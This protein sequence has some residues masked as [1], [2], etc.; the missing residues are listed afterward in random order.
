MSRYVREQEDP[1]AQRAM[2][3]ILFGII[4]VHYFQQCLLLM[5]YET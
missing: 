1:E 5:I 4:D 2:A 3:T